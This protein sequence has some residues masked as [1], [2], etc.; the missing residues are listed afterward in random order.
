MFAKKFIALF[1]FTLAVSS[2]F[3]LAHGQAQQDKDKLAQ[4]AFAIFKQHCLECHGEN[5]KDSQTFLLDHKAMIGEGKVIPG[6]PEESLVYKVIFSGKMPEEAE[7]LPDSKIA[8][9]KDWILAGAPDWK[10]AK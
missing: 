10:T 5:G 7:K 4:S 9:I 6:K 1:F 2:L 8:T 3:N